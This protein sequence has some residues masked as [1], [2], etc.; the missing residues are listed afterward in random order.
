[1]SEIINPYQSPE[2]EAIPEKSIAQGYITENMRTHLKKA[3]PWLRFVGIVGFIFSGLTVLTGF[4][5][6]PLTTRSFSNVPGFEQAGGSFSLLFNLGIAV[7]GLGAA[8]LFFFLSLFVYRF[9]DKIR[10]YLVT[11]MEQ[12]LEMAFKNNGK[13]WKMLGILCII[14]LAFFPLMIISSIIV[15]VSTIFA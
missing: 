7:Y 15:V 13:L 2:T 3:S 4:V 11:G 9:G 8:S 10:S 6:F 12:D 5:L 14:S 1:M